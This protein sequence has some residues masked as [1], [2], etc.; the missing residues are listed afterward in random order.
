MVIGKG[1]RHINIR[2]HYIRDMVA[3]GEIAFE[4][5]GTDDQKGD[6]FTKVFGLTQYIRMR[7]GVMNQPGNMYE[8]KKEKKG[9]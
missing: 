9:E 2:Y 6:F 8:L 3:K 1:S 5:V 7:D 4:L